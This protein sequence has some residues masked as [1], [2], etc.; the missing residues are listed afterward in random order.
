MHLIYTSREIIHN[1]NLDETRRTE[2]KLWARVVVGGA[3]R[4]H[5]EPSEELQKTDEG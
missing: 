3:A 1:R 5:A 4:R 2:E